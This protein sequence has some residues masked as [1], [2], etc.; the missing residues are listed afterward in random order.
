MVYVPTGKKEDY[1]PY[2][3]LKQDKEL[4]EYEY[5]VKEVN[6]NFDSEFAKLVIKGFEYLYTT[7]FDGETRDKLERAGIVFEYVLNPDQT[8]SYKLVLNDAAKAFISPCYLNIAIVEGEMEEMVLAA[9]DGNVQGNSDTIDEALDEEGKAFIKMLVDK[10]L[11]KKK[12]VRLHE[13]LI[14]LDEDT[15]IC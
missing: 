12:K 9:A 14:D 10:K 6:I 4:E 5:L 15:E 8:N 7:Q 3:E 11:L 13:E 1:L 2:F